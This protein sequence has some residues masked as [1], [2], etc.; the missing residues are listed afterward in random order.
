MVAQALRSLCGAAVLS[1]SLLDGSS[2]ISPP[3]CSWARSVRAR[4]A[5]ESGPGEAGQTHVLVSH[6]IRSH[7]L[8]CVTFECD[9]CRLHPLFHRSKEHLASAVDYRD[10]TL[11]DGPTVTLEKPIGTRVAAV[12]TAHNNLS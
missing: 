1:Q 3:S 10:C 12:V 8:P 2:N 9:R 7:R 5:P 6:P 4:A 11:Q